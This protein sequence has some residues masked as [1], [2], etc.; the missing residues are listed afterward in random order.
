MT[1]RHRVFFLHGESDR[2]DD[3]KKWKRG[4]RDYIDEDECVY[5]MRIDEMK[6]NRSRLH[7]AVGYY[8]LRI[9]HV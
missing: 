1:S 5:A 7:I 2:K 3:D 6:M 4:R 9:E 8:C